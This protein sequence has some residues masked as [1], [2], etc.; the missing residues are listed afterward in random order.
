MRSL[1]TASVAVVALTMACGSDGTERPTSLV[2]RTCAEA[3]YE[4]LTPPGTV[5]GERGMPVG[6]AFKRGDGQYR[7]TS[8]RVELLSPDAKL[9]HLGSADPIVTRANK[10]L[11]AREERDFEAS[12]RQ[13][14]FVFDGKN[15][16][17]EAL[18]PGRYPLVMELR[19]A[20]AG[21]CHLPGG[22]WSGVLST[23]DWR[24]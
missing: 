18:A 19:T 10:P 17:G 14:S 4:S 16:A 5:P 2:P 9:D 20:P 23:I 21:Q 7:V 22:M 15:D 12:D 6:L 11:R 1:T 13:V 24:G 8:V 3:S